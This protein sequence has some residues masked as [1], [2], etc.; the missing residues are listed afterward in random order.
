[1][2]DQKRYFPA[3]ADNAKWLAGNFALENLHF[4]DLTLQAHC[5]NFGYNQASP[6]NLLTASGD[7][8]LCYLPHGRS[9]V[10]GK[11]SEGV[12]F[13]RM[14][15]SMPPA[16]IIPVLP[17]PNVREAVDWLRETFGFTARLRTGTIVINFSL[18]KVPWWLHM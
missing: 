1:M 11:N 17:Y 14:N 12:L 15:R 4:L 8:F 6:R 10:R 9:P 18:E 7:L 3:E 5:D 13:F 16:V 2:K